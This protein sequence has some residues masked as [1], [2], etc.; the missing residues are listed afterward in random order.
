MYKRRTDLS[1]IISPIAEDTVVAT[2][3]VCGT[4][5]PHLRDFALSFAEVFLLSLRQKLGT[6]S[7]SQDDGVSHSVIMQTEVNSSF[8]IPNQ[9]SLGDQP[10][11]VW[12]KKQA[13]SH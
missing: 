2:H 11:N 5:W 1:F 7:N 12:K 10:I 9:Q 4:T 3:V 13:W 8:V 6:S